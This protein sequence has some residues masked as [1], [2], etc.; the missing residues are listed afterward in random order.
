MSGSMH[1]LAVREHDRLEAEHERMVGRHV[2]ALDALTL[3]VAELERDLADLA[4]RLSLA[5]RAL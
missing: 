5:R 3:R 4:D 2:V 1:D